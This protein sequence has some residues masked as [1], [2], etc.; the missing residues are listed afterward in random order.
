MKCLKC[1]A[2][3]PD[4]A[5]KCPECQYPVNSESGQEPAAEASENVTAETES[6]A[7]PAEETV[8]PEPAEEAAQPEPSEAP[9]EEAAQPEPSE[10]AAQPAAPSAPSKKGGKGPVIAVAAVAVVAVGAFAVVKLTAP[11]PKEVVIQAFENV[12][13]EDQVLPFEEIF[14][15]SDML[16]ASSTSNTQGSMTLVM[17]SCSDETVGAYAGTGIRLGSRSDMDNFKSDVNMALVYNGMD[18]AN[19][20]FYYGDDTLMMSMPELTGKVFTVDL[21]EGLA[22]RLK[23]SPTL[24]PVL[25]ESGV[26]VDGLAAYITEYFDWAESVSEEGEMPFDVAALLERY[27]EG[28]TA[29]DSFKEALTVEKAEKGTYTVDGAEVSCQGYTVQ[30][31]K[32]AMI[33]FLRTSSDFFLQ[34]ETFK[35]DYLQQLEMSVRMSELMGAAAGLEGQSAEEMLQQ[36]Y[37]EIEDGAAQMIDYLDQVLNDVQMTVY[38]DKDGN[39]AAVEGTTSITAAAPAAEE[40]GADESAAENG[41]G[42]AQADESAAEESQADEGSADSAQAGTGEQ[43]DISFAFQLMGGAYATQNMSG[44]VSI[45]SGGETV[46]LD[47]LKQGVYDDAQLTCDASVDVSAGGS[48]VSIMYTGTYSIGDGS[49]HASLEAGADGSQVFAVSASG[50][51]DQ[52]EKGSAIHMDIDAMDISFM[53]NTGSVTLSGEYSF[54]PLEGEI[55]PLEG[56]TMDALAATEEDW[57]TVLMEIVFGAIGLSGQMA[58]PAE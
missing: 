10:E 25:T 11:D 47:L 33:D 28:C 14:G 48:V 5:E 27:K 38:V 4:G 24:G 20:N 42:D 43:A 37:G 32:A 58:A 54:G 30:V 36:T 31:S 19:I 34:D 3:I 49:Y 45:T 29:Y 15:L 12:Y 56:E 7:A 55:A 23:A 40:A 6:A 18:L 41:S 46:S 8:Q 53:D 17:D 26:D 16:E 21:G 2:L 52:L 57:S 50:V 44:N 39:L 35:E 9:A 22:D 1:G 13:P 51:V